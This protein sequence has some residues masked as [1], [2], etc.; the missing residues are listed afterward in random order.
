MKLWLAAV[1][2]ALLAAQTF[3]V[4]S[5]KPSKSGERNTTN[6]PLGPGDLFQPTG[7]LFSTTAQPVFQYIAFAYKL[8]GN[9]IQFLQPQ[10]PG[11]AMTEPFDIQARAS[12]NPTKDQMRTMMR[13]LLADRFKF[14]THNETR[15]LP[16][17]AMMLVKPGVPG[18]QLMPH[19]D[20]ASCSTNPAGSSDP[21]AAI[22]ATLHSPAGDLP[23]MCNGMFPMPA[24]ARGRQRFAGRNVT[25]GFIG[26]SLSAGAGLGRPM[27]DQTGLKGTFDFIVEFTVEN[28]NGPPP[29][30][31]ADPDTFALGFQDALRTQLG[32]KLVS[33]KGPVN[34]MVVDHVERPSAN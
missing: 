2:P 19:P 16:V 9:Q 18:P 30:V 15:Q 21:A 20:S 8:A 5:I 31:D 4:A 1:M 29:P 23:L 24:S 22:A 28:R 32:I 34:V 33:Q 14:A 27:L 13:A 10:L 25:V 6:V 26:D 11:W 17:L 12:G 3:D 7:G